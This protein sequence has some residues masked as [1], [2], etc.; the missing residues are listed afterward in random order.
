MFLVTIGNDIIV[1]KFKANAGDIL[2]VIV[3]RE[4]I[5]FLVNMSENVMFWWLFKNPVQ[6]FP[7]V[8]S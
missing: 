1:I 6:L 3:W 8:N 7:K 5:S 4:F 2:Y